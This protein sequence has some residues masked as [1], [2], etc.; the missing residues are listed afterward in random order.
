MFVKLCG[1]RTPEDV[2]VAVEAGADAVGFVFTTSPRQVSPDAVRR[3]LA[4]VPTHVLSVG[5]VHGITAAEA[6][7]LAHAAGVDA[8][9]LHGAYPREAFDELKDLRL[10]R[11]TSLTA[12]TDVVTGAF[13]EEWLLL[14]SPV[15]GSGER[16]DL[17]ALNA[18][19]PSGHWLLAGGLS[20]DNVAEAIATAQPWGVD[21]SSGVE[22]SRGVKDH[23]RMRAFVAAARH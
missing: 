23:G 17:T 10:L 6:R 14:D 15:A 20:P 9:Q 8:L 5:V 4:G 16:W 18:T 19:R 3:L 22:S 11:A 13:G 21:V 7:E 2:A 1:L 12:D